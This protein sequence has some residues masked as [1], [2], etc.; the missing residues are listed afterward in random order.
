MPPSA[1]QASV[2]ARGAASLGLTVVDYLRPALVAILVATLVARPLVPTELA[3]ETGAGIPFAIVTLALAVVWLTLG[4]IDGRLRVRHSAADTAAAVL[5][6]LHSLAAA[7]AV[8]HAAP[9]PA[10]NMAWEWIGLFAGYL[11]LRQLLVSMREQRALMAAMAALAVAIAAQGT[12]QAFYSLPKLRRQYIN[13]PERMVQEALG[14][15][16]SSEARMLFEQRLAS[17]EPFATFA[18]PNSLAGFLATWLVVLLAMVVLGS[19]AGAKTWQWVWCRLS[20]V[21]VVPVV[22][23]C[24]LLTKS[25]AAWI[26]VL[27]GMIA[28]GAWLAVRRWRLGWRG[29][30]LAVVIVGVLLA[31]GG[32]G[33]WLADPLLLEEAPKSLLYRWEYWQGTAGLIAAHPLLGCGP[34]NFQDSYTRYK[35]PLASE[36][37]ADPHNFL[38]EVWATAGTPAAIALLAWLGLVFWRALKA[39]PVEEQELLNARDATAWIVGGLAGGVIMAHWQ[40]LLAVTVPRPEESWW[41]T[42]KLLADMAVQ[43]ALVLPVMFLLR[44]WVVVGRLLAGVPA[45]A[46]FVL[47]LHFLVSGGIGIPGVAVSLWLLAAVTLNASQGKAGVSHISRSAVVPWVV[48]ALLLTVGCYS[49]AYLPT[50]KSSTLLAQSQGAEDQDVEGILLAAQRSDPYA[51][52]P[53]WMLADW[54][55]LNCA[56]AQS[57]D[58]RDAAFERFERYVQQAIARRPHSS[59]AYRR[60]AEKYRRIWNESKQTWGLKRRLRVL[61]TAIEYYRQAIERYPNNIEHRFWLAV[62]LAARIEAM[63]ESQSEQANRLRQQLAEECRRALELDRLTPHRNKK[64]DV[65]QRQGLEGMLKELQGGAQ[66]TKRA[67]PPNR[68]EEKREPQPSNPR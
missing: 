26:A 36:E 52:E 27:A 34:G 40:D 20:A 1:A 5:V 12:Y 9:R 16:A 62:V 28:G 51:S 55:L 47:I 29:G 53:L 10:I 44:P 67:K 25:R 22:A 18:L 48:L 54:E 23:F 57:N 45:L 43:L 14:L 24:L 63:G 35:L 33:A 65:G 61:D 32:A 42:A 17:N 59:A 60:A 41:E 56:R 6:V 21:V 31:A 50:M 8:K 30:I 39:P 37:V 13:D 7:W 15:N 64:L 3:Q 19:Q 11:L 2:A 68:A 66:R 46:L 58:E 4:L 49:T 38:L